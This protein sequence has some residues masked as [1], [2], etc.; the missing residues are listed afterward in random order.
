MLLGEKIRKLRKEKKLTLDGLAEATESSKS[1][2]WELENKREATPS[3]DKLFK[4]A[5]V[6][7]VTVDYLIDDKKETPNDEVKEKAFYRKFSTL[8]PEKQKA[9]ETLMEA[10]D[11]E[12]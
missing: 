4:I 12:E 8:T 6:L 2:M 1:Y 10:M 11:G 5:K 9:L 7:G 3:A